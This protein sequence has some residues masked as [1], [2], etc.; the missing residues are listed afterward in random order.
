MKSGVRLIDVEIGRHDWSALEC[1]CGKAAAHL[2]DDL[3]RLAA[4]QS[5]HEARALH[6][7]DHALIQS[8]P[9]E[10]AVPVTSVLMAALAGDL[11]DG[12][13]LVCLDLLGRLVDTDDEDSAQACQEIARQGLWL[14]YRDLWSGISRGAT[15]CAYYVL[16]V[17]ETDEE[18]LHAFK[19]SGQFELCE[20]LAD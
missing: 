18:R 5:S 11:S 13:R 8:F 6:I 16:R 19:D 3:L 14:L 20:D 15:D 12:A 17:I 1:G 2:A 4:A 9:Q 10:P 7:D